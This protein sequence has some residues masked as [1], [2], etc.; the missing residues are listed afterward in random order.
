MKHIVH[1]TY[2][3]EADRQEIV[4]LIPAEQAKV[5]QLHKEGILEAVYVSKDVKQGWLVFAS[6][7]ANSVIKALESLPLYPFWSTE[8]VLVNTPPLG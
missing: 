1:F 7:D 5:A 6:E 3:P 4:K 2:T 8:L